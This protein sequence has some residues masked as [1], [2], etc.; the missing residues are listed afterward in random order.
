[1]KPIAKYRL[2]RLCGNL[3]LTAAVITGLAA[4]ATP[5]YGPAP[6]T[7][8]ILLMVLLASTPLFILGIYL[9]RLSKRFR[10]EVEMDSYVANLDDRNPNNHKEGT[11]E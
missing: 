1:M 11:A 8:S 2:T 5:D 6:S 7:R 4:I 9:R 10:D 3:S